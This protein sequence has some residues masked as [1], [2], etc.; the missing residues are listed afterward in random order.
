LS[1]ART[2]FYLEYKLAKLLI[3]PLD[4]KYPANRY[5]I[6]GYS[7]QSDSAG[8]SSIPSHLSTQRQPTGVPSHVLSRL[9][10]LTRSTPACLGR[11]T[12]LSAQI[13]IKTSL[14]FP[15]VL[16][17][18]PF[19]ASDHLR[20][21]LQL[22]RCQSDSSIEMTNG[23]PTTAWTSADEPVVTPVH[24]SRDAGSTSSTDPE[25]TKFHMGRSSG[26]PFSEARKI[27]QFDLN[28]A[29]K[30]KE[31]LQDS[32]VSP[33]F[34]NAALQQLK[35]DILGTR[36]GMNNFRDFLHGTLGIYLLDFWI[37]CEDFMEHTR[38][39]ETRAAPQELQLF[40]FST[41]R[42]IQAKY[43]LTVPPATRPK[44]Q[45]VLERLGGC[46]RVEETALA[47]LSRKQY[48][49]LRRLRCYW[50]PRFL[51]HH[52]R[53][54]QLRLEP[55]SGFR[56]EEE[57]FMSSYKMATLLPV[58]YDQKDKEN[59]RKRNK[60]RRMQ[61]R[62]NGGSEFSPAE[63]LALSEDPFETL[64]STRFLQVLMSD[65]GDGD[66]FLH[67]LA[68]FENPQEMHYLWLW[69]N[70]K[71]YQMTWEHQENPSEAHQIALQ[72]LHTF[73]ASYTECD[74]GLSS[75]LL[76]YV[77]HLERLLSSGSGDLKPSTFE[78][79]IRYVLAILGGAWLRYLRHEVTTFLE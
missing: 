77:Q 56:T 36:A 7:R 21:R 33:G 9:P 54:S 48:D 57:L 18:G 28:E 62:R 2:V 32:Y 70:L 5:A 4:E 44:G 30:T 58:M 12:S 52:Q 20:S 14:E 46:A 26:K 76:E 8:V 25:F 29:P 75:S 66:S 71:L 63:Q 10:S 23:R 40:F 59:Y 39:L 51:I 41:L 31:E 42:S 47:A 68:R 1:S 3:C 67:Y 6:R 65:F 79:M 37:D 34:G 38:H 13:P 24:L 55:S 74:T 60:D 50:V 53:T 11:S 61:L 35:E 22:H 27:L 72:I 17:L 78:P 45:C 15:G 16:N 49:A 73:L 64:M 43:K 19:S 69:K